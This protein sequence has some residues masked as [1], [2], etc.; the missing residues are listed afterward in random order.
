MVGPC[1]T[2]VETL[3]LAVIAAAGRGTRFLPSTKAMP[4]EL[5]PLLD[6][7][8]I[9]HLVEE[10]AAA[11]IPEVVIVTRSSAGELLRRYFSPDSDWDEYLAG[12]G[13]AHLLQPLYELLE[14]VHISFVVQP[15]EL[16]YGNGAP[17]LSVCHRLQAPFVYLYGDDLILETTLGDTLRSLLELYG[18]EN[19]TAVVGAYRVPR[20]T[21]SHVGSIA[22]RP[23]GSWGVD[24]IVEKPGPEEAPS[25]FT[26]IGRQV[27]SPD[28]VPVLERLAQDLQ[29]GQELWMTDALSMLAR[30]GRVLAPQIRGRWLTTGDP[31]N[32]LRASLAFSQAEALRKAEGTSPR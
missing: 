30:R 2:P 16:P 3:P 19:A 7:P 29:P 12:Q 17:I 32:L 10:I 6:R 27:L 31:E 5:L 9:H 23:G 8:V 14:R 28:I 26:P 13:K 20:A 24:H 11:G 1:S 22:Y 25:E 4:K 18:A 15:P 21:I